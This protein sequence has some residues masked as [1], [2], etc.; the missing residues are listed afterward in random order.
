MNQKNGI[1]QIFINKEVVEVAEGTTLSMILSERGLDAPG[2]AVAVDGRVISRDT[3]SEF[4]L[5]PEA[6]IIVIKAACGG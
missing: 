1:M 2:T 4:V 5:Q 3:R 6:K